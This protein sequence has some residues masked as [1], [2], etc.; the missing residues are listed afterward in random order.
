MAASLLSGCGFLHRH[1]D[2]K[3]VDY[4]RSV[5]ERPLEVPPDLDRPSSASALIVPAVAGSPSAAAAPASDAPAGAASP[6]AAT[7]ASVGSSGTALGGDGL[8]VADT[9][10][11]TWSRVGLALERSGAAKVISRDESG[12]TYAVQ[13]TGRTTTKPGWFKRAI[14]FGRAG[15]KTTSQ[16]QLTVRTSADGSGSKVS[17]EGASD[18]A[19]RDAA[20]ALLESLRQ[21]LS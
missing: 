12:H 6:M 13:T 21:R 5:E 2:R 19:S 9:V 4:K 3:E 1:F 11:S 17:V 16:V 14:T 8:R 15:T 10:D 7:P 18:E 20:D